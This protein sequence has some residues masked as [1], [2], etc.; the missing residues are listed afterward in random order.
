MS[1][2]TVITESTGLTSA[3]NTPRSTVRSI[4]YP[5]RFEAEA[6]SQIG[7]PRL[8]LNGLFDALVESVETTAIQRACPRWSPPVGRN[9]AAQTTPLTMH[10]ANL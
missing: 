10:E 6:R 2:P 8:D 1:L 9:A 7:G 4:A 5:R 3:S